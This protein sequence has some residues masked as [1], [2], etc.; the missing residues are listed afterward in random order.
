LSNYAK[1]G[2]EGKCTFYRY[3]EIGADGKG[4]VDFTSFEDL[5]QDRKFHKFAIKKDEIA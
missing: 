2:C 4:E 1:I 3:Q 5:A